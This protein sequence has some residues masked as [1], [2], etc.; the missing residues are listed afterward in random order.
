MRD[1]QMVFLIISL[2][3]YPESSGYYCNIHVVIEDGLFEMWNRDS[4]I[5]K[6]SVTRIISNLNR[7]YTGTV[8]QEMGLQFQAAKITIGTDVCSGPITSIHSKQCLMKFSQMTNSTEYCTSLL[9][10]LQ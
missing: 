9:V 4:E 3:F 6:S 7:I 5:A 8:F 10:Y 2:L 1:P